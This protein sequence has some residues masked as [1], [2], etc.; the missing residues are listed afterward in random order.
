MEAILQEVGTVECDALV[1][2]SDD[3]RTVEEKLAELVRRLVEQG[4][5]NAQ[6]W[7]EFFGEAEW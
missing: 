3:L 7:K 4:V 6:R 5:I 1:A 2:D